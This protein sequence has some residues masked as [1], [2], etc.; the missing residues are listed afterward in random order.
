MASVRSPT[1]TVSRSLV[2]G[3]IAAHT[4]WGDRDR[5][6]MASSSLTAPACTALSRVKRSS[7]WTCVTRTSCK[8]YCEKGTVQI[9]VDSFHAT[10]GGRKMVI[11]HE[12]HWIDHHRAPQRQ[13][14]EV[15]QTSRFNSSNSY[16]YCHAGLAQSRRLR[17]NDADRQGL[18]HLGVIGVIRSHALN[19]AFNIKRLS[20]SRR[21]ENRF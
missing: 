19:I 18:S 11:T 6:V 8:K 13:H 17:Q 4:Q 2:T 3:S 15:Y 9:P 21:D 12:I 20:V 7:S 5:R 14:Y 1:S 16:P 10:S